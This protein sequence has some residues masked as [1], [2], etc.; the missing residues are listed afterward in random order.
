MSNPV[1]M[2]DRWGEVHSVTWDDDLGQW[3]G[4]VQ[5][6]GLKGQPLRASW[7]KDA[8]SPWGPSAAHQQPGPATSERPDYAGRMAG[9][10]ETRK[11]QIP[12]DEIPF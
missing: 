5:G 12:V 2:V 1:E 4:E 8:L 3:V 11:S 9:P 7:P 6:T 10:G